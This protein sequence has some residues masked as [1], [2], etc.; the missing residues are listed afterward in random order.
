MH[1]DDDRRLGRERGPR[2]ERKNHRR[3]NLHEAP[4]KEMKS[5]HGRFLCPLFLR[6]RSRQA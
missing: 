6:R 3:G 5:L 1:T 4:P 2:T